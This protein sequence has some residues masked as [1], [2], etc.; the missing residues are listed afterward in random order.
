MTPRV[1]G[2]TGLAAGPLG[3]GGAALGNLYAPVEDA[4]A[5]ATID[6]ALD[7]GVTLVDTAPFYGFGLSERRIGDA[8][9]AR[10]PRPIVSTKVGRLLEP[11]RGPTTL[12]R[13]GFASLM[14]FRPTFDYSQDGVLRSHE[15]S[16]HRLGLD[17]V[18]LLLVHDIGALTHGADA[19]LHWQALT[20][21]GGLGALHAL[22]DQG[23]IKGIGVGVNEVAAALAVLAIADLDVIL[24]AGRYTLLEQGALDELLPLCAARNVAVLIGGPFNSGILATGASGAQVGAYDYAAPAPPILARIAAMEAVCARH[25]VRLAAAALQFPLGHPAVAVVLPGM[26]SPEQVAQAIQDQNAPLPADFWAELKAE[27]LLRAD[28]PVSAP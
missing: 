7:G 21:G 9:R 16:L 15:A 11:D 22:R 2:G 28:A 13:F 8:L 6:A 4:A 17:R 23:A 27:G 26:E 24:I 19:D 1:L 20:K 3:F 18:D 12:P 10:S 25:D 14:P 5:R